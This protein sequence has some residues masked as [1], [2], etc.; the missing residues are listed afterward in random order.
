MYIHYGA[1]VF[2]CKRFNSIK[3]RKT[4]SKPLGGFWA[5]PLTE[6]GS[7]RWADWCH[8]EQ[9]PCDLRKSFMFELPLNAR[10]LKIDNV[11]TLRKLPKAAPDEF[12]VV[13]L[14]YEEI[15]KSYDAVEFHISNSEKLYYA[16]FGIETDAVL[17]LNPDVMSNAAVFP[18]GKACVTSLSNFC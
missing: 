10:V 12:D 16:L 17:V 11:R 9:Y 3:N 1:M 6:K 2:D 15:S 14:D 5:A 7:S 8:R 13:Y 18:K 4:H